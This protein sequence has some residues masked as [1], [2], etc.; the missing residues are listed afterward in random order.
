MESKKI[1]LNKLK[2]NTGQIE[3]VP[4]NPRFIKDERFQRLIQNIQNYPDMLELRE[5]IVYDNNSELIVICGNMRLRA[6]RELKMES[7]V[8]KILAGLMSR[9]TICLACAFASPF[10][11]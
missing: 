11:V 7:S 4:K 10:T 9:C 8:I 2:L 1:K 5:I 3:N 6:L